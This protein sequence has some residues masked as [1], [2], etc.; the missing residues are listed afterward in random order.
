VTAPVTPA[1]RARASCAR[2]GVPFFVADPEAIRAIAATIV[3][4]MK[5]EPD[6]QIPGSAAL[7]VRRERRAPAA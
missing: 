5:A 1:D 2:Q 4:S 6:G 7:E 3:Q